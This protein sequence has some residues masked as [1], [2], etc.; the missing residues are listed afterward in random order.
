VASRNGGADHVNSAGRTTL[1]ASDRF[2]RPGRVLIV[3]SRSVETVEQI[4]RTRG[5]PAF[6]RR[7]R[8]VNRGRQG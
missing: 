7:Q 5:L 6:P 3:E 8:P 4:I 1:V 2:N